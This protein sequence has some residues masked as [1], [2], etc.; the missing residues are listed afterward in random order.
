MALV[1]TN[2]SEEGITSIIGVDRI[3]ELGMLAITSNCYYCQLLVTANVRSLLILSTLMMEAVRSFET[4]VLTRA[5]RYHLSEDG[6]LDSH[7]HENLKS[8]NFHL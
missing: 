5:T 3:S 6:I 2:I 8:Y 1:R 7:P 4:S